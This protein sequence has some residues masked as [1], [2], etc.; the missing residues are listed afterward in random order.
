MNLCHINIYLTWHKTQ[1]NRKNHTEWTFKRELWEDWIRK[2]IAYEYL[3]EISNGKNVCSRK[4]C[5]NWEIKN[6]HNS[7]TRTFLA[8]LCENTCIFLWRLSNTIVQYQHSRFLYNSP[9]SDRELIQDLGTLWILID[10]EYSF[11][12]IMGFYKKV[13]NVFFLTFN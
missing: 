12:E 11:F 6:T 8:K 10:V 4:K 9:P 5:K 3:T 2:K 13:S 1:L 7:K